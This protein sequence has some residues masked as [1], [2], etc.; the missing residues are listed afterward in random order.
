MNWS[1]GQVCREFAKFRNACPQTADNPCY[2]YH[3]GA[4]SVSL[5][6]RKPISIEHTLVLQHSKEQ[7][8]KC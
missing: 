6:T 8:P 7:A 2:E 1:P 5:N 4:D 3:E